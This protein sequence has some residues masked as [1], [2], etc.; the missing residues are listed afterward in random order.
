MVVR[1]C[2]VVAC[3][4]FSTHVHAAEPADTDKLPA[5]KSLSY[6]DS[7]ALH[8][9]AFGAVDFELA[10]DDYRG[11]VKKKI[12]TYLMI[13]RKGHAR[14]RKRSSGVLTV[15]TR[16]GVSCTVRAEVR[17]H[18]DLED[19]YPG[20]ISEE[21]SLN[22][23]LVDGHIFGITKFILFRPETRNGEN[24]VFVTTLLSEMKFLA[25]RSSMSTFRIAGSARKPAKVIFQE[26][27][28]KEFLEI[29]GVREG[30]V[31]EGDERFTFG[32]KYRHLNRGGGLARMSN[33]KWAL[34]GPS[35]MAI[36]Q[37]AVEQMNRM[38]FRYDM[39]LSNNHMIDISELSRMLANGGRALRFV[40]LPLFEAIVLSTGASHGLSQDDRRLVYD[41]LSDSFQPIYYDGGAIIFSNP[42]K[43][44]E[45]KR[46][47]SE[48]K[49]SKITVSAQNSVPEAKKRLAG[50]NQN[51]LHEALNKRDVKVSLAQL[52]ATLG[53][54]QQRLDWMAKTKQLE[55]AKVKTRTIYRRPNN[56][57]SYIFTT[58]SPNKYE[59]C[60]DSLTECRVITSSPKLSAKLLA[61]EW[62]DAQGYVG[63]YF[64][65]PRS[66]MDQPFEDFGTP[67]DEII[68]R[69]SFDV[70]GF[71]LDVYGDATG[72]V[73]VGERT[74][75]VSR[76]GSSGRAVVSNGELKGWSVRMTD[77]S[78]H[79]KN[80]QA[81][82]QN[83]DQLGLTGCLTFV[84]V[85]IEDL[86][87]EVADATCEDGV[88][89]V[90]VTGNVRNGTINTTAFDA[91]D[92]DFSQMRIDNLHVN[93]AGND[94]L[95]LSYGVYEAI[96]LELLNCG[97]KAVSV[98]ETS[99]A[100][101]EELV[102]KNA[103]IG[104]AAKDYGSII[105]EK[106]R[107][108]GSTR[109][110][111]LYNKKLE[112]SGGRLEIRSGGLDCQG[113]SGRVGP[114]STAIGADNS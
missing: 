106:G 45:R 19:H 17:G 87:F 16:S 22:I 41:P 113:A 82:E 67:T 81:G 98:G 23:N 26:K 49:Y 102:A 70:P 93:N 65:F 4:A 104:L 50:L 71:R 18:G 100:K 44:Y 88:N 47:H 72:K 7:L 97:D 92:A 6:E 80:E 38:Y 83:F 109:C 84:D 56:L 42:G 94:C 20:D 105:L 91:L 75:E 101:I 11:W 63:I 89:F 9:D 43:L 5:C 10:F 68:K 55:L 12:K 54:M 90:R 59:V 78:G 73:N 3:L 96:N 86:Q 85:K 25:P 64:S 69:Q 51:R 28:V 24:E 57:V 108:E 74:I 29:N 53:N 110:F 13:V 8:P 111:D 27:I 76:F 32:Q 36:S 14:K 2:I 62:V 34:K 103:A 112:F 99:K 1:W 33:F 48:R 15:H 114:T 21:P 79:V 30:P 46:T 31:V 52:D 61:Q 39:N 40:D 60:S 35:S 37:R 95:D 77:T 58:S 107:V 66:E